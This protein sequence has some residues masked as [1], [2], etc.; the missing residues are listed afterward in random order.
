MGAGRGADPYT[1]GMFI[2]YDQPKRAQMSPYRLEARKNMDGK[3]PLVSQTKGL[4][5]P[6]RI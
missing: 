6:W 2:P 1:Q 3:V 5:S 4:E